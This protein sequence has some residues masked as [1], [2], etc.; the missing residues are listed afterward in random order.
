MISSTG[1][2]ASGSGG[3][4]T[5]GRIIGAGEGS[6]T[7]LKRVVAGLACTSGLLKL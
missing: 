4:I 1:F 5:L 6:V 3:F 7:M 2:A